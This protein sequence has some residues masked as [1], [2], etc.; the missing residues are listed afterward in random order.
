MI[1]RSTCTLSTLCIVGFLGSSSAHGQSLTEAAA[2]EKERRRK[3]AESSLPVPASGT[4]RAASAAPAAAAE[5]HTESWWRSHSR[6]CREAVADAEAQV[7]YYQARIDEAKTP[8]PADSTQPAAPPRVMTETEK[9]EAE[10][11]L[12]T[13][14]KQLAAARKQMGDL[15]E[16]ARRE[17]VPPEWLR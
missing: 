6:T 10:A 9:R 5:I 14:Q 11:S 7:K 2:K 1:N 4:P 12:A 8:P 16:Q 13:A 17:Q 15:E 3:A